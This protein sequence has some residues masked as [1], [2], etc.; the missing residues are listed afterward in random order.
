MR[1]KLAV[2]GFYRWIKWASAPTCSMKCIAIWVIIDCLY[3]YRSLYSSRVEHDVMLFM[4]VRHDIC[5]HIYH[6]CSNCKCVSR[7]VFVICINWPWSHDKNIIVSHRHRNLLHEQKMSSVLPTTT[8]SQRC[9]I[10]THPEQ[11][12]ICE[13]YPSIYSRNTDMKPQL[14]IVSAYIGLLHDPGRLYHPLRLTCR[15]V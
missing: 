9:A 8:N 4:C 7:R 11:L 1:N 13:I 14:L 6:C 5:N 2:Y 3:I 15:K 12:M 10:Y